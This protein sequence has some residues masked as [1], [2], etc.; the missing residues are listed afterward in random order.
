LL[1]RQHPVAIFLVAAVTLTLAVQTAP[2]LA[3]HRVIPGRTLPSRL[4]LDMEE[5]AS[6][7]SE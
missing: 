7:R 6:T 1:A 2:P 3:L 4:G 5:A